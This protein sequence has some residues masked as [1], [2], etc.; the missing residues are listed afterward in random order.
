MNF[1][2]EYQ[3]QMLVSATQPGWLDIV[4][5]AFL[6]E[7]F[8]PDLQKAAAWIK[9]TFRTY[10]KPPSIAQLRQHIDSNLFL[11]KIQKGPA[12][13]DRDNLRLFNRHSLMRS[14][15]LEAQEILQDPDGDVDGIPALFRMNGTVADDS[16]DFWSSKKKKRESI[17]DSGI[18]TLDL[19][20]GGLCRGELALVM[21]A[22]N[23]GKTAWAT[24]MGARNVA[25]G[26]NVV[27][28]SLEMPEDQTVT[29]YQQAL[30]CYDLKVKDRGTLNLI[31]GSPHVV[32][33]Q[34]IE[35]KAATHKPD[36]IIVDS[37]D[38]LKPPRMWGS[39]WDEETEAFEEIK[40]M[41][42]RLNCVVWMT[43]QTGVEGF[44]T[45]LIE[46]QHV[47]GSKG[48]VMIADQVLSINQNKSEAFADPET[49]MSFARL[50]L[51][52]NRYG[53]RNVTAHVEIHFATSSFEEVVE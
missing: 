31:C 18:E 10:K 50:Y 48:K 4:G 9:K 7:S 3:E 43:T 2:R 47:K 8:D 28:V 33:P 45:N 17:L 13:L 53:P 38:L 51:A 30:D 1:N 25:S 37:G 49:G 42:Q 20:M 16:V 27:H 23:G 35:N 22:S 24:A 11:P 26:L 39:K 46:L 40:G 21:A 6:S 15:V 32:T 34:E 41:A 36:L 52:K 19:A 14:K 12:K 44:S 5:D 29:K